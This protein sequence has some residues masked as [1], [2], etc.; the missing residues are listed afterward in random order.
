MPALDDI[1][2]FLLSNDSNL[3]PDELVVA[4]VA[5]DNLPAKTNELLE[6]VLTVLAT[7]PF[8]KRRG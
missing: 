5:F 2:T 1:A 3:M 6:Y 7:P 4:F 8:V